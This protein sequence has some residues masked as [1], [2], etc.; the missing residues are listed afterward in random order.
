MKPE[1]AWAGAK[2]AKAKRR[3][4]IGDGGGGGCK[5]ERNVDW[6]QREKMLLACWFL[7]V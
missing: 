2:S 6:Q 5:S 7:I 4:T 1:R 3:E